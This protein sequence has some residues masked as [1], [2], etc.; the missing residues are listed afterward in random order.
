[1][2]RGVGNFFSNAPLVIAV[3]C[4]N[5]VNCEDAAFFLFSDHFLRRADA[6]RSSMGSGKGECGYSDRA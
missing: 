5:C 2:V 4:Y 1:M 6:Y 3:E